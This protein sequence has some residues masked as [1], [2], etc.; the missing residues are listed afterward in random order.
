MKENFLFCVLINVDPVRN[1]LNQILEEL[2][3]WNRLKLSN[4]GGHFKKQRKFLTGW[5]IN[6][7][8]TL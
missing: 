5:T 4:N 6:I 2:K 8:N 1:S 7:I 3:Q